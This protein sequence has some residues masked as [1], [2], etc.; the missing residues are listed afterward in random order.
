[1]ELRGFPC[2]RLRAG[3]ALYRIYRAGREPCFFSSARGRF[4]PPV[5]GL[6]ACYLALDPLGAWVEVFRTPVLVD[7]DDVATRRLFTMRLEREIVVADVRD[8]G[9]LAFGVTAS[10][11][12]GMDR[13]ASRGFAGRV[14]EHGVGGVVYPLRHDPASA[15]EGVALFGPASVADPPPAGQH[16]PIPGTLV[17]A[18]AEAFGYAVLPRAERP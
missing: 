5:P 2:R 18:A 10:V 4:D 6:G 9:A 13:A 3:T 12:A 17:S 11:A 1:M 14:V 7:E 16:A 8:R 15:L